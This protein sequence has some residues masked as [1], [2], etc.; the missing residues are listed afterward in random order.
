MAEARPAAKWNHESTSLQLLDYI[1]QEYNLLPILEE[2][3]L[4]AK[5]VVFIKELICGPLQKKNYEGRG[6]EKYFLYEFIA[7]KISSVDVDKWDYMLRD[8]AAMEV[9]ILFNYKRFINNSDI[10]LVEGMMRQGE[11]EPGL[12]FPR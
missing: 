7:N 3:G 2:H 9:K 12:P 4:S 6:P 1:I 11:R 10:T 5:D 8:A